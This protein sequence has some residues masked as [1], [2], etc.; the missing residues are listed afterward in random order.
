MSHSPQAKLEPEEDPDWVLSDLEQLQREIDA[1]RPEA[2]QQ[3]LRRD[4]SPADSALSLPNE[5]AAGSPK[6]G[7]MEGPCEPGA[8][9]TPRQVQ[10]ELEPAT[11]A[12]EFPMW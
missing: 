2:L 11:A 4:G 6:G 5:H 12:S 8:L 9:A 1:R 3:P 10:L 7:A